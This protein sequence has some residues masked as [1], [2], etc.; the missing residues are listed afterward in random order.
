MFESRIS[1]F[2]EFLFKFWVTISLSV[3]NT[4][5]AN[6]CILMLLAHVLQYD[7]TVEITIPAAMLI[8]PLDIQ[9]GCPLPLRTTHQIF[10]ELDYLGI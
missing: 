4:A 5:T 9:I 7:L 1:V 3:N 10:L 6:I 2:K 8:C